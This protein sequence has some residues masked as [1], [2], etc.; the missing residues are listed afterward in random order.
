M[1]PASQA[2][3]SQHNPRKSRKKL[4]VL[5]DAPASSS[6]LARANREICQHIH[7][8]LSDR[9]ELATFGLGANASQR[10]PWFQYPVMRIDNMVLP[11]LGEICRDFFGSERGIVTTIWNC[12]WLAWLADPAAKLPQSPLREYLS[13]GPNNSRPFDLW[14]YVPIDGHTP[15]GRLP[16]DSVDAL[17]GADRLLAYTR[18]GA[19][20]IDRALG[21]PLGTTAYLP[22]GIDTSQFYPRDR[23]LARQSFISRVSG[24]PSNT[25]P[26]RD[27]MILLSAIATNSP[28]KDWG[29]AFETCAELLTRDLNIFFWGH[30][31]AAVKHWN[32][33]QLATEYNMQQRTILTCSPIS[34]DNLAWAYSACDCCLSIGSGEGF[35]YTSFEPLACGVPVIHSD[36]AGSAEFLLPQY[37]VTPASYRMETNSMILRPVASAAV[38]ATAVEANLG[39]PASLPPKLDWNNLWPRW[40]AWIERGI[41]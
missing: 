6:G 38:W 15:S 32:L 16:A 12:S 35:G 10:F 2:S 33:P 36:Y 18:Y 14:M 19:D 37:K 1:S 13:S 22:H 24:N 4:L 21:Q 3:A 11:D 40:R 28:R 26:L 9:I 29:L 39:Q 5:S 25:L 41:A 8:D 23:S 17:R 7:A 34:N 31:D 27:D 30:T 20:V